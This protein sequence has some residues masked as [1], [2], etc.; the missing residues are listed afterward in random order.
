MR[1]TDQ[2]SV[3]NGV[4]ELF[5]GSHVAGE[6]YYNY[7]KLYETYWITAFAFWL[8]SL[9]GGIWSPVF[10]GNV[11]TGIVFWATTIAAVFLLARARPRPPVLAL[12]CYLSTP[13][14]LL[15]AVY[16]NPAIISAGFLLLAG[17][18]LS[19]SQTA[20]HRAM[21]AIFF[22]ISVGARADAV[23]LAPLLLWLQLP[24]RNWLRRALTNATTW[25]LFCSGLAAVLIGRVLYTGDPIYAWPGFVGTKAFVGYLVFGLGASLL[26][27][28]L[29]CSVL[30]I[31]AV[32]AANFERAI[33]Y[34]TGAV[35]LA[36][37]LVYYSFQLWS[38][39]YLVTTAVG[40]SLLS[41]S[42]RGEALLKIKSLKPVVHPARLTFGAIAMLLLIAGLRLPSPATPRLTFN[43]PTLF[44]TADGLH[45]TG[46]YL[47]FLF[48]IRNI[49][50]REIDHNQLVWTAAMSAEFAPSS[51][52]F[53]HV[54]NTPMRAYVA[55]AVALKGLRP[56][57]EPMGETQ[58]PFYTESRSFMRL[59]SDQV[60]AS[61]ASLL[62]EPATIVSPIYK[63]IAIVRFNAGGNSSWGMRTRALDTLFMGNEYRLYNPSV[64]NS[65]GDMD[66]HPFA[67]LADR[68]F[69][70]VLGRN[71]A[72]ATMDQGSG[73]YYFKGDSRQVQTRY[74]LSLHRPEHV[75][76]AIQVLPTWMSVRDR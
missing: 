42:R 1:E 32:R 71:K 13:A 57:L 25:L 29:F 9:F 70:I 39:R 66:G 47:S 35:T 26:L 15:N 5:R 28:V 63:G 16:T 31:S 73:L 21:A 30:L 45:P 40:V 41:V 60:S 4:W 6:N 51:D 65:Y 27:F 18:L 64:F 33:F 11:S 44:P 24:S 46:A 34:A 2:A 74:K 58:G 19:N 75:M 37:P 49:R 12:F 7:E 55:L 10:V 54:L 76:L 20:R 69:E 50:E 53:V 3:L 62:A 67:L 36:L 68:P 61:L 59:G 72:K 56:K 23:L 52:G 38:P 43:Q 14:I 22:F 8:R 48:T 17:V